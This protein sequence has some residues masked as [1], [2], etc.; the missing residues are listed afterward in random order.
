GARGE[1][2]NLVHNVVSTI[3]DDNAYPAED[4]EKGRIIGKALDEHREAETHR[5]RERTAIENLATERGDDPAKIKNPARYKDS[6]QR[7]AEI[8]A[9]LAAKQTATQKAP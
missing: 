8:R 7:E 3:T 2:G 6:V 5:R 1:A 9:R 4:I